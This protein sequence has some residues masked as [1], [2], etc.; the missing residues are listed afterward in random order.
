MR[1]H[2]W[3][4]TGRSEEEAQHRQLAVECRCPNAPFL[5]IQLKRPSILRRRI[6][7]RTPQKPRKMPHP[8]QIH[9]LRFGLQPF[10]LHIFEKSLV[11]RRYTLI[12]HKNLLLVRLRRSQSSN[13]F[14]SLQNHRAP[15][16][17]KHTPKT[18]IPRER[19]GPC[20]HT[21]PLVAG[22]AA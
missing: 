19:F 10:D 9:R 20:P 21:A 2:S 13:R 5:H 7:W 15:T 16:Y 17:A 1:L 6:I 11:Q 12:G 22:D 14:V 4:G 8:A 18:P 3:S